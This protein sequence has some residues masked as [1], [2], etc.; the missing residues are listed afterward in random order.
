[1]AEPAPAGDG[2]SERAP[3]PHYEVAD[4]VRAYGRA[5][6]VTHR[7][8]AQ[9]R[10]VLRAIAQCRTAAATLQRFAADPT[11]RGAELGITAVLH[12]WGQTLTEHV[13]LHCVVTGG[14]LSPEGR[15]V[16]LPKGRRNRLFLFPVRALS[17]L[18]R[19]KFCEGLQPLHAHGKLRWGA[20]VRR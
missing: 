3:R 7:L 2:G 19:A 9:Q 12:T 11:H 20:R 18:F 13:H 5:F 16:D 4:V 6:T 10:R 17:K 15:W 1:V 14:G 8:S